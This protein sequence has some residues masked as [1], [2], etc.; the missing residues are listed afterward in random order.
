MMGALA[1]GAWTVGLACFFASPLFVLGALVR[2]W[3]TGR[4][5]SGGWALWFVW[6]VTPL[7]V[8]FIAWHSAFH[9][10]L[11]DYVGAPFF[12]VAALSAAGH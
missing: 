3:V 8:P 1:G 2:H 5:L 12:L 4:P 7:W 10:E 6:L 9:H 11:R